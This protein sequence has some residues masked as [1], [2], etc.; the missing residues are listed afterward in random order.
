[1]D[2]VYFT[3]T[4]LVDLNITLLRPADLTSKVYRNALS[5]SVCIYATEQRVSVILRKRPQ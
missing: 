2:T 4:V 1:M 5:E 3:W